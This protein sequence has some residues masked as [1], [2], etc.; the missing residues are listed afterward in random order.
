MPKTK[1]LTREEQEKQEREAMAK[2]IRVIANCYRDN[3]PIYEI[4]GVIHVSPS[5]L[6]RRW[7]GSVDWD[8]PTLIRVCDALGVP[9]IERARMLGGGKR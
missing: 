1:P 7:N 6:Q 2:R 5:G 3:V 8:V 9:D 4:A